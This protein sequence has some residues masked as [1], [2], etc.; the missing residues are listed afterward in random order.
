MPSTEPS[1]STFLRRSSRRISRTCVSLLVPLLFD[2]MMRSS[3]GGRSL[4]YLGVFTSLVNQTIPCLL[5][6][7]LLS[8]HTGWLFP[9]NCS[10]RAKVSGGV[11]AAA[12]LTL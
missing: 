3:L 10:W 2:L 4:F 6:F 12:D 7:Y 8:S 9:P 5:G 1:I 11:I